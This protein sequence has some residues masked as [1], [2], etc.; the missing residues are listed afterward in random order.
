MFCRLT[1]WQCHRVPV[2]FCMSASLGASALIAGILL[3]VHLHLCI[4]ICIYVAYMIDVPIHVMY[5]YKA[6]W[7]KHHGMATVHLR[8]S[9]PPSLKCSVARVRYM[10]KRP[11]QPGHATFY[12]GGGE[13]TNALNDPGVFASQSKQWNL[14][15][16]FF[17]FKKPESLSIVVLQ[18]LLILWYH[19]HWVVNRQT[20]FDGHVLFLIITILRYI[21]ERSSNL[22]Q[23]LK[24]FS[25]T[26]RPASAEAKNSNAT[27]GCVLV[28]DAV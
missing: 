28:I 26:G 14:S 16:S 18:E 12:L 19:Y 15:H 22:P 8:Y 17:F 3:I 9:P 11:C 10:A 4:L 25:C 13:S 6:D 23:V 5:T 20:V 7:K 1:L 24:Y 21:Y 27:M 2:G